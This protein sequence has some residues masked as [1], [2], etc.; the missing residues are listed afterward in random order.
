MNLSKFLKERIL[1]LRLHLF[2]ISSPSHFPVC[3]GHQ[4]I[5]IFSSARSNRW[6]RQALQWHLPI[7]QASLMLH[8]S[9][10]LILPAT[11]A[12]PKTQGHCTSGN[13]TAMSPD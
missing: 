3:L 7:S 11:P 10:H 5:Y 12:T 2:G 4:G 9:E 8:N 1:R 6:E 13:L